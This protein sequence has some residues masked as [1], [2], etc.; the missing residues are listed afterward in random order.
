MDTKK[1]FAG[2]FTLTFAG[3]IIYNAA[4]QFIVYPLLSKK[5]GDTVYGEVLYFIG[6]F[7]ITSVALGLAS[8]NTRLVQRNKY[9][10]SNGDCMS[11]NLIAIALFTIVCL[12]LLLFQKTSVS[13]IISVLIIQA[14][15]SIRYYSE[16]TYKINVDFKKYLIYYVVV[17][18]GYLVGTALFYF[19]EQWWLPFVLGELSGIVFSFSTSELKESPLKTSNHFVKFAKN[20]TPLLVSYILYYLVMNLDRIIIRNMLNSE[21]VGPYYTST[22][23]GKTAAMIVGPLSGIIIGY[24]TKENTTIDKKKF[25]KLI[26]LSTAGGVV[27]FLLTLIATPIFTKIFYPNY[28]DEVKSIMVLVNFGQVMCFVSELILTIV[29]IFKSE[30]W[31]LIVQFIYAAIFVITS[32]VCVK[33]SGLIGM[34][35]ATSIANAIRLVLAIFIGYSKD[36]RIKQA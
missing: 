13:N 30:K 29:L 4:L 17:T 35:I 22:L 34:A 3:L 12:S 28:Y 9:S 10:I 15:M 8:L 25:T 2:D 36:R 7:S 19:T 11:Y 14:L 33:T 21:S 26:T 32:V 20:T 24:I 6:I 27:F 31:Q 18:A 23:I 5:L 16:V 1:K